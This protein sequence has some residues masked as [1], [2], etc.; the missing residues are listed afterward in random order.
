M[1]DKFWSWTTEN[2]PDNAFIQLLLGTNKTELLKWLA[3]VSF[4]L[5]YIRI[6]ETK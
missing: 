5:I 6:I 2:K 3:L 4:Y 1:Y